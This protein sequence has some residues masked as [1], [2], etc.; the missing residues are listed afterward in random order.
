MCIH[1]QQ[2]TANGWNHGSWG[3]IPNFSES[4]RNPLRADPSAAPGRETEPPSFRIKQLLNQRTKQLKGINRMKRKKRLISLA[5]ICSSV[6]LLA[7][8][9][10]G[11]DQSGETGDTGAPTFGDPGRDDPGATDL[12]RDL[13]HSPTPPPAPESDPMADPDGANQAPPN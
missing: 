13:D 8:C 2:Q 4:L 11:T 9:E 1:S 3:L 7:A 10:P 5:A 12:D 6:F